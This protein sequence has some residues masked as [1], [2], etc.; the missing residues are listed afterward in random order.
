[1]NKI[2]VRACGISD[3]SR[4]EA[5]IEQS[6]HAPYFEG[7]DMIGAENYWLL[8]E[9]EDDVLG[10]MLIAFGKPYAFIDFLCLTDGLSDIDRGRAVSM[11]TAEADAILTSSGASFIISAIPHELKT[12]RRVAKRRGYR[13][14]ASGALVA[15]RVA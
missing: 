11:L 10:C 3:L 14:T 15:K 5:L 7:M 9:R 6:E 2:A 4:L 8:A 12:C 1:M 13:T